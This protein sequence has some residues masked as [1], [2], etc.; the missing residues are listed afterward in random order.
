MSIS[1]ERLADLERH[2]QSIGTAIE[3]TTLL[4]TAAALRELQQWRSGVHPQ[5]GAMV[6][7][8]VVREPWTA[9]TD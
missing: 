2:Y 9:E 5:T 8:L 1:D 6:G 3:A 7:C 4:E